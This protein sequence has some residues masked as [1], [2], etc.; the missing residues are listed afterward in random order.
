MQPEEADLSWEVPVINSE[1]KEFIEGC[2]FLLTAKA[3]CVAYSTTLVENTGLQS[4][5]GVCK[6]L[7]G[8][9]VS[10]HTH[11]H[12]H[13]HTRTHTHTHTHAH[14]AHARA[15]TQT[16]PPPT[17]TH[18]H[19][20]P[21]QSYGEGV[22]GG[23]VSGSCDGSRRYPGEETETGPITNPVTGRGNGPSWQHQFSSYTTVCTVGALIM[24]RSK[25]NY[26]S[27]VTQN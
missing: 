4:A 16:H 17:H 9:M 19:T 8:S 3:R 20:P 26:F 24:R 22:L 7:Y 10:A 21:P 13:T 14:T 27:L 23:G 2:G 18:P 1:Q 6:A 15:H 5:L 11:A 12:A 25:N